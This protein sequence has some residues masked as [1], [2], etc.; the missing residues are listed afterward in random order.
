MSRP[1]LVELDLRLPP[2]VATSVGS[3]PA[4]PALREAR[5]AHAQGT[6]GDSA[7]ADQIQQAR[8]YWIQA[9][10]RLAMDV[11]V[12][13]ALDGHDVVTRFTDRLEGF[14][15]GGLVRIY[16][17]RY[18]H[19][20]LITGPIAWRAPIGV[21][22]WRAV[23][24][25]TQRPV[26]ARVTGPYTLMQW[27]FLGY[28]GTRDAACLAIA[29]ALRHELDA[30]VA[31]GARLIQVD[32]P[33][34]ADPGAEW[35]LAADALRMV[36]DG[37]GA[38]VMAHTCREAD[39]TLAST[40]ADL[41]LPVDNVDVLPLAIVEAPA[42]SGDATLGILS[43]RLSAPPPSIELERDLQGAIARY[44]SDH[45]WISPDCG[46]AHVSPETAEAH[47]EAIVRTVAAARAAL[48]GGSP[49]AAATAPEPEHDGV[50]VP[51]S[52]EE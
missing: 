9:Q 26:K 25:L 10:E 3:L 46:L 42:P 51:E 47:L 16:G 32:E 40:S 44:G 1:T 33:A 23:Q 2:L 36:T 21:D 49:I 34:L 4:P 20:P 50:T 52:T 28:Y 8:A 39:A 19:K 43:S 48:P 35:P 24:S 38:Y 12:D 22:D 30:L 17:N 37:L 7:L 31:A 29:A 14:A 15:A 45:L 13:G 27:S 5:R 18:R 11:L 41:T 6:L